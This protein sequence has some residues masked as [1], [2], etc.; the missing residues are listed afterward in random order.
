ML[1]KF[2]R[3]ALDALKKA[4]VKKDLGQPLQHSKTNP[5]DC[6]KIAAVD[7][8]KFIGIERKEIINKK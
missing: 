4:S 5:A 1:S 8:H 6:R 3:K 2:L 7:S